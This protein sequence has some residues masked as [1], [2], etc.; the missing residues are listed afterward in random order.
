MPFDPSIPFVE[1]CPDEMVILS[2]NYFLQYCLYWMILFKPPI[3]WFVK[4][5]KNN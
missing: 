1:F 2:P 5:G 3:S 4:P